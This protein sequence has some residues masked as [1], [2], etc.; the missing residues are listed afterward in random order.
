VPS[1]RRRRR[2]PNANGAGS[3]PTGVRVTVAA[4]V[5]RVFD[6][7]AIVPDTALLVPGAAGAADVLTEV[8]DAALA[9][10]AD[11]LAAEPARI[12]VVAPGTADRMRPG[13]FVADLGAAGIDSGTL[14]W[15]VPPSHPDVT[16]TVVHGPAAC[17]A[18][19]LLGRSGWTGPV[20][21]IEVTPPGEEEFT[22][23][24]LRASE[25]AALGQGVTAGVER[26]GVLVVG[27]L[28]A[29]RGP[30]APLAENPRAV[31]VDGGMLTDLADAGP[32]ARSRLAVMA[33][34]LA[35]ELAVSAWAPL[36]VLLGAVGRRAAVEATAR[37][38]SA[39]LGV[40]YA[41][42]AWTTA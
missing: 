1:G 8:R 17:V 35:A 20:T 14:D 36:Q 32:Q 26:V 23:A 11:L 3:R 18:L 7:A 30:D 33:P 31:A 9:A 34:A 41:V 13:P 42:A 16:P 38:V 28:S 2:A 29:R 21:L 24:P 5:S 19:L 39:P 15:S 22:Q 37:H 4:T 40:T 12:V 27:S 25:L 6:Y 10:V